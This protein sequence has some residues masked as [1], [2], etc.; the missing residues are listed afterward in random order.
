[1]CIAGLTDGKKF[2]NDWE[3]IKK[4]CTAAKIHVNGSLAA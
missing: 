3:M 2:L 4:K 1:M